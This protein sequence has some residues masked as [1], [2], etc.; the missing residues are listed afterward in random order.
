MCV[1]VCVCVFV[2]GMMAFDLIQ[3]I[4]VDPFKIIATF[5]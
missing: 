4:H 2:S 3:R 1:Y 5:S